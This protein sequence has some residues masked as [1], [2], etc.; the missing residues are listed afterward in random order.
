MRNI[1]PLIWNEKKWAKLQK[2]DSQ[3]K[4]SSMIG[5]PHST[6]NKKKDSG[7]V[8]WIYDCGAEGK[9]IITFKNG[10]I[11]KRTCL[12]NSCIKYSRPKGRILH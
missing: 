9:R 2:G 10:F 6:G 12:A 4:V 1:D 5:E 3:A 7:Q 8:T 11:E